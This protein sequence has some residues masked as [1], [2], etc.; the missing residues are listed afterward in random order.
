MKKKPV[1]RGSAVA[2]VTPFDSLGVDYDALL[3]LVDRQIDAGTDALVVL[4]TTGEPST[5][6]D[7]ERRAVLSAVIE[8]AGRP[9]SR[10]RGTG[11]TTP[12]APYISRGRPPP[13][14]RTRSFA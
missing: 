8:R 4:G 5:L 10:S 6:A 14:A 9:D 7:S 3:R 11:R 13:S 12:A 2:L 1:F